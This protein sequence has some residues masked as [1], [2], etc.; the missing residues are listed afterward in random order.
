M[1]FICAH[2]QRDSIEGEVS[3]AQVLPAREIMEKA[4]ARAPKGGYAGEVSADEKVSELAAMMTGTAS[5][6][7]VIDQDGKRIGQVTRDAVI[8]VL[9]RG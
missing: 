4:P 2:I 3:P 6:L 9:M 8:S 1:E 5:I 7:A